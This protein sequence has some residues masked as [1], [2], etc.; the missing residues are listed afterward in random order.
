MIISHAQ[1]LLT[2]KIAEESRKKH[3]MI[4]SL[5][6]NCFIIK[7]LQLKDHNLLILSNSGF[8]MVFI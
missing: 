1:C 6:Q 2:H 5:F 7:F 4:K 3:N 8:S